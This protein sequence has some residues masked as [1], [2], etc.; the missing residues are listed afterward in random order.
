MDPKS[1]KI[2]AWGHPGGHLGRSGAPLGTKFGKVTQKTVRVRPPGCPFGVHFCTKN[3]KITKKV[4]TE[5][6]LGG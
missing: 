2:E 5:S 3:G 4:I 6:Q 1:S